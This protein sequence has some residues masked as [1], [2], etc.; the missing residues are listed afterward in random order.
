M[1]NRIG[2]PKA[3]TATAR[4]LACLFYR[5]LKYGQDYVEQGL[6]SYEKQYQDRMIE[7]LKKR[8]TKLGFKL[9]TTDLTTGEVC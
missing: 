9:V 5:L 2:T 3:V 4:K 6:K 1:K 7:N 8:A